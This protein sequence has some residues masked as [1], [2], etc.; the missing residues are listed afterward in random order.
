MSRRAEGATVRYNERFEFRV[1]AEAGRRLRLAAERTGRTPSDFLRTLVRQLD[2][3]ALTTGVPSPTLPE[4]QASE[5]ESVA[6]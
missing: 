2:L 6:A 4:A 1:D 5:R 3:A